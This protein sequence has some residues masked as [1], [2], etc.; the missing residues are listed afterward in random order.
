MSAESGR[1]T[2]SALV[3]LI[4]EVVESNF[5]TVTVEGEMSN[6]AMPAS[7]HWY[8]T[9]KDSKA[10]LR[11][12]MFRGRN[13]L[14]PERPHDGQRVVCRGAVTVYSARGEMQLV[15]EEL[16]PAGLGD[17]QRAFEALKQKLDAE[18]LFATTR[19]RALPEFPLTVGVVTSATG[20]AIHDILNVLRRRAAGLRLLLCPVRVQG[21]GAAAEIAAAIELLNNDASSD[22]LIVGRGGG[23]IEDLWAFNEEVVARAIAGSTIPVISAVGHEVD[24]TIADLVADVRAPTPSAAA[25]IVAKNRLELEAHLDHLLVRLH[26]CVRQ[27][28]RLLGERLDRHDTRLHAAARELAARQQ[29][30]VQLQTRLTRAMQT[31]LRQR[32]DQLAT[33]AGRLEALS[34]LRQLARGYAIVSRERDGAGLD[35][36]KALRVG[37]PLW[38]RLS[39]GRLRSRIEEVE[40]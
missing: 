32:A 1:L 35:S 12:V 3:A 37:D 4:G 36:V 20:A 22:V 14:L 28:L 2:V 6:L 8:F 33:H 25:E 7:G 23:S 31:L 21:E 9:L 11:A 16:V 19:K 24:I 29:P 26:S 10:Q 5:V 17:L 27:S 18:G 13:R 15:V 40:E 39:D 34:P 38:V 30:V